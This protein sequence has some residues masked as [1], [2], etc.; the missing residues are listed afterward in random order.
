MREDRRGVIGL[1]CLLLAT[2]L[3]APPPA[4][5]K[6]SAAEAAQLDGELTPVG[7]LRAGNADGSIPAWEGGIG[8]PP[9]CY[10]SGQRYCD[11]WPQ[12]RPLYTV[13][14]RNALQYRERLS[15]GQRA[16]LAKNPSS[17][18]I[19]VYPTHRS[20]ALPPAVYEATRRN[21]TRS[22]LSIGGEGVRDAVLGLPFP[23]PKNAHE[24]IWNHKLRYRG[25]QVQRWNNQFAVHA[26]GNRMQIR[27]NE[28]VRFAYTEPGATP[29]SL[30]NVLVYIV[31]RVVAPPRLAGSITLVHETM[32]QVGEPRRAWQYSPG[33]RRLRRAPN[34]GYDNPG[35]GSDALRTNDQFDTYNGAMDRYSWKLLGKREMLVPANAY[36]LHSERQSY[37]QILLR[38]HLNQAL[39]RYELRR[40]WV[41][42]STLKPAT[43]H[44]Y[45]RRTFYV[46]EDSWQIVLVDAYDNRGQL[47]RWQEAHTV[48]A[49][50]RPYTMPV[51]ELVYDLQA[52]RYLAMALNNQDRE[53]AETHFDSR[54]FEPA[55]VYRLAER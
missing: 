6:V 31:Q 46:D 41:V 52:G 33:Q 15:G 2:L 16:M 53:T 45:H 42:E 27:I 5:A 44:M 55:S 26:N 48:A 25:T 13:D 30:N 32:D 1:P 34:V 38:P 50:D 36:R 20:S 54:H 37:D 3:L 14:A 18:R 21:A 51:A 17:Y 35:T 22:E 8:K 47:W 29:E 12:E 49:Y 40:V 7:A 10:R 43:S 9:S 24:V 19:E 28:D 23:I 4:G 39:A 11:P